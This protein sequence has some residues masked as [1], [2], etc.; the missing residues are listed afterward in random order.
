MG[1]CA[2]ANPNGFLMVPLR[3]R[4]RCGA[5]ARAELRG[6]PCYFDVT[7]VPGLSLLLWHLVM[8][9]HFRKLQKFQEKMDE[10]FRPLSDLLFG[11][12]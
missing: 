9:S 2:K 7:L 12:S 5:A 1:R 11:R 6:E 4:F 10:D 3:G 8:A